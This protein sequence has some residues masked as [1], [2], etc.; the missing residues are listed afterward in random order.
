MLANYYKVTVPENF[1]DQVIPQMLKVQNHFMDNI[2]GCIKYQFTQDLEDKTILYLFVIWENKALY[3]I[4]LDSN[5]QK[6]EVFDKLIEYNSAIISA[7]Q[8]TISEHS[9]VA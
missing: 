5:Y 1:L 9:D 7:E 6:K 4:N 3:E 8:F 2:D